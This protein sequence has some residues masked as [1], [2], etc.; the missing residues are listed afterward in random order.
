MIFHQINWKSKKKMLAL[1]ASFEEIRL[2]DE[3]LISMQTAAATGANAD[4]ERSRLLAIEALKR[5]REQ[6][7]F[8][9]NN[10]V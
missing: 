5:I 9:W 8:S 1:S 2:L 6:E 4:F 10:L 7:A 3:H